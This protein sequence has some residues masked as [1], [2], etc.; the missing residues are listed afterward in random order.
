MSERAAQ[1]TA[2]LAPPL[3]EGLAPPAVRPG[4]L[5]AAVCL[6][7]LPG[8][9]SFTMIVVALPVIADS[10]HV[11]DSTASWLLIAPML[12]SSTLQSIGGRLGDLL[13][14]RRVMLAAMLGYALVTASAALAPSFWVLVG[15]RA[16]QVTFGGAVAPNGGALVRLHLPAARRAG[17]YGTI[18]AAISV[19]ATGGPLLG[20]VLAGTLGWRAIFLTALPLSIAAL[21]L[22]S[23]AAPPD[24]VRPAGVRPNFDGVGALLL[25]GSV[26]S[27]IVPLTLLRIDVLTLAQLPLA[28]AALSLVIATFVWWELRHP[29]PLVQVRLFADRT[30]RSA[31]VSETLANISLFPFAVVVSIFLQSVQQRSAAL[32]GLVIAIGSVTM[33]L[34]SPIGGRMADRRGRRLPALIGRALLL[35]GTAPLVLLTRDTHP[36]MQAICMAITSAGLGM[37]YPAMQAAAIESAPRRYAGMAAGVFSTTSFVGGVVGIT[38]VS[39]YLR[40]DHLHVSQFR[41]IYAAFTVAAAF[42]FVVALRVAPWPRHVEEALSPSDAPAG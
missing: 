23:R 8:P 18:S 29:D 14:Y 22:M 39:V 17:A 20:G 40:G 15:I 41:L 38:A 35:L 3:A 21:V 9:L 24:S 6:A 19:A 36:A 2:E 33:I 32:S 13:G 31:C 10:F 27:L 28:Y 37:S 30:Y 42:S 7:T 1:A 34:F 5:L 26:A 16:L 25:A 12:F 4:P 11:S